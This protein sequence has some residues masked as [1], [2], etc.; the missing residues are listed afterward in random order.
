MTTTLPSALPDTPTPAARRSRRRVVLRAVSWLLAVVGGVG[1]LGSAGL[2][3]VY[4][5]YTNA[6]QHVSVA[7]L[8]TSTTAA[9]ATP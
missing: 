8:R 6:I 3:G 2:L 5:H 9:V 1:L 4:V 7:G